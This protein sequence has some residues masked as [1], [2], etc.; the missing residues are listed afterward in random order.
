MDARQFDVLII[1]GGIAGLSAALTLD[2]GLSVAIVAKGKIK[3]SNTWMAQGGIAV[4]W[5]PDDSPEYHFEDTMRVGQGLCDPVAVRVLVEEA[6]PAVEFLLEIGAEFDRE[7]GRIRLAMEGGHSRARVIHSGDSTGSTVAA[8]L[9]KE[10]SRRG[11]LTLFDGCFVTDLFQSGGRVGGAFV[12]EHGSSSAMLLRAAVTLLA[13][14]GLGQIYQA[15]TNPLAATGD[16]FAMGAR[17]GAEMFG[18]EFVQF[19]P[20]GLWSDENPRFLI[21][22][23]VR[24]DGAYLLDEGGH[25][26]MLGVHPLAELAPRDVVS[27]ETARI[28][29]RQELD[30]V[31]LD[32]R[33]LGA[34]YL[35][36][37]FPRLYEECAR[38]GYDMATG[39]VPVTPV[40]HYMIGGVKTD[41]DCATNLPG[42]FACGEVAYSG[43]HGANRLAS[44]SLLEGLVFGRRFARKINA[45]DDLGQASSP[46]QAARRQLTAPAGGVSK[47]GADDIKVALRSVMSRHAWIFREAAGLEQGLRE[48]DEL[49][50]R[51]GPGP[52][53]SLTA[54]EAANMVEV[55]RLV[56]AGA[57]SRRSSI[58]T[59]TR[60]DED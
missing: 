43:V 5:D 18:M 22:E 36:R 32:A 34:D 4:A 30:H 39:L 53:G 52:Y 55:A 33:H 44:N 50:R 35:P 2:P 47:K 45:L 31:F 20:T 10:A 58:G 40:A 54:W 1:G 42:L 12:V 8:T 11:N 26:Y 3:Q 56:L 27:A 38:H 29:A 46:G 21:S 7:E 19:H 24:G 49:L 17:A 28:M 48:V 14:G 9:G 16:G 23:A 6:R 25:R 57:L 41:L 15:T 51:L 13:A 60:T 37:R 59:H